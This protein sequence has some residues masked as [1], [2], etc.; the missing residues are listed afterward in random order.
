MLWLVAGVALLIVP[1]LLASR[2]PPPQVTVA[3]AVRANLSTVISSNGKVEPIE[4]HTL[5]AQFDT[6]VERVIAAEGR[7]VKQG[8]LLATLNAAD[9]RAEVARLREQLVAAQEELRTGRTG[10]NAAEVAQ[11]DS[12]IRQAELDVARL[13]KERES[14]ERL[15]AKQAAT[16]NEVDLAKA[17]LVRAEDSLRVLQQKRAELRR[18]AE[19]S[20]E[21]GS[22]QLEQTRAALQAAGEK[23]ASARVTAPA[24][25][26]LYAL[27]IK[28]G[29]FVRTGD[30][31]AELADLKRVQVRAFVDE[32]EL[33]ML[34]AGQDVE[35][36]WDAM[37][38]RT[39]QG[40][41]E[42]IPKAVVARGN[43]SVGEV[44][45]SVENAQLALLPNTNVDVRIN[46]RQHANALAVPR[47]AVRTEGA[48]R[49]V[50]V[51][52]GGSLRRRAVKV[53][54]ASTTQYEILE[55]LSEGDRVALPGDATLH[56]GMAVR[57]AGEI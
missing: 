26:T 13:R 5:R 1:A 9:I 14:L 36:N 7:P 38:G 25:G 10:G 28:A 30:L 50:Y 41:T 47:A 53:G 15:L 39:W 42:Q 35:I 43:R 52:D 19:L 11:V 6:F 33:G 16:Q 48:E 44:L 21:R 51:L 23:L 40:R 27:P 37:P 54:I 2:E 46:V 45:C 17:A 29:Q 8:E 32:P 24:A 55:G 34:S 3:R 22:L 57:V 56:D 49:V 31:L 12:D 4:P 20:A 18:T